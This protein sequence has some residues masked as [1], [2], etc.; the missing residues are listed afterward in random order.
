MPSLMAITKIRKLGAKPLARCLS[1]HTQI[2]P[3]NSILVM[4][5]VMIVA[6]P[7]HLAGT[8]KEKERGA[9]PAVPAAPVQGGAV[10]KV[11]GQ[12]SRHSQCQRS[13]GRQLIRSRW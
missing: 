11:V 6:E 7:T 12:T 1:Q 3:I 10:G 5:V 13:P 8:V 9:V 4:I 2:T